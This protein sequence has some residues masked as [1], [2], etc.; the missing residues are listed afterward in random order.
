MTRGARAARTLTATSALLA[1][2]ACSQ[3]PIVATVRTFNRPVQAVLVCL[4]T[5]SGNPR[6]ISDCTLDSS[7]VTPTGLAMHALVLQEARGEVASVDLVAR[8]VM[9]ADPAI[10][11]YSFVAVNPLPTAIVVPETTP[12]CAFVTSAAEDTIEAID[13]HQFRSEGL[14][15]AVEHDPIE[16]AGAATAMVLDPSE[17]ALWVAMPERSS[18]ARI[19]I[20][21]CAFGA[22]EEIAL[23]AT[24]PDGIVGAPEDDRATSRYCPATFTPA[25]LPTIMPR[26]VEPLDV[27][28]R[29][30][31]LAVGRELL[32]GDRALPLI[33][34][35][36]FAARVPLAPIAAGA[37]I[38]SL[39]VTPEVPNSFDATS[40]DRSRY[41][42]AVDDA[43]GTVLAVEY[44]DPASPAFG[45]VLP[46]GAASSVRP[47]RMPFLTGART[48][49]V[50]QPRYDE[51]TP[52]DNLCDPANIPDDIAAPAY[53]TLRGVFLA[54][55][56]TDSTVRF[57]DVFD[58]DAP[59][60]GRVEGATEDCTSTSETF[61][62]ER[63]HHPR[64]GE[65]RTT[66]GV[67]ANDVS[68]LVNGATVRLSESSEELTSITCPSSLDPIFGTVADGTV[69][70][71][72]HSDPY[73]A[74]TE[75][76]SA[77]WQGA[78]SGTA[79]STGNFSRLDDGSIA[80]DAR[81]DFCAA[82]VLGAAQVASAPAPESGF[83]G[84]VIAIT[85]TLTSTMAEVDRCKAVV[86]IEGS[87]QSP[88]PVLVPIASSSTRPDG[89]LEPYRGRLI[90]DASAPVLDR[91]TA[92]LTLEDVLTCFGDQLVRFDVRVRDSFSVIGSRSGQR[93]RVIR[94]DDG[95]CEVDETLSVSRQSRAQAGA[96]FA[97]DLVAF[98]IA[99]R[100]STDSTELRVTIGTVPATLNLDVGAVA[101]STSRG[102][103]L[104]SDIVWSSVYERM[105]IVDVERRG[106]IELT[107]QPLVYTQSR[108]E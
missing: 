108:F 15:A 62:Y 88:R 6:T 17:A 33:H 18:V 23:E 86:G 25:P 71:C 93:H 31:V 43:D 36:D 83:G 45:A 7:G 96:L 89:L 60:R 61:V 34:R 97:N 56:M 38:R 46:V 85:N 51:L 65:R 79:S 70:V 1:L 72:G 8:K 76:W 58:S 52:F 49:E 100:P 42:Y 20:E 95:T 10:P 82:G 87:S 16:L 67:T 98:Q 27:V 69:R 103:A 5:G 66:V 4:E 30:A 35:V 101:S 80:L 13:L 14:A 77:A 91:A 90:F 3:T 11:G 41:V 44:S 53:S 55:G 73:E 59:C 54:I 28:A 74:V 37:T 92:G 21:G 107:M 102:L 26:E 19:P 29:P 9:D 84:D 99:A 63:R 105:Y 48:L 81:V 2:G 68:F 12:S 32:V 40:P 22:L 64:V 24:V 57:V 75:I 47:D 39:A 78:I 94:A 106:L 104:P 50:I